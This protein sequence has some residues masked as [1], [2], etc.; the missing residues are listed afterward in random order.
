MRVKNWP[1]SKYR[2][3]PKLRPKLRPK[4]QPKLRPKL[5]SELRP[6]LR[7]QLRPKFRPKLRPKLSSVQRSDPGSDLSCDLSFD[8]CW[9]VSFAMC[10]QNHNYV[11][12][13]THSIAKACVLLWFV[14][15]CT[16]DSL[17]HYSWQWLQ[18][19]IGHMHLCNQLK[20]ND[21]PMRQVPQVLVHLETSWFRWIH[22]TMCG[23]GNN[24][25]LF[26]QLMQ[27]HTAVSRASM[28]LARIRCEMLGY[29]CPGPLAY[30][31]VFL[32]VPLGSLWPILLGVSHRT[33]PWGL[34]WLSLFRHVDL[35]PYIF[36]ARSE[37]RTWVAVGHLGLAQV[38]AVLGDCF[39]SL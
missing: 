34:S 27:W 5:C 23:V 24:A 6:R 14:E 30:G 18:F 37:I 2:I 19:R 12:Q 35:F 25:F 31:L 38:P 7:P 3:W 16:Q 8:L 21:L 39:R 1:L 26:I 11:H 36:P 17:L 9:R 13:G 28:V 20:H 4:L 22:L 33:W 10:S 15:W 32:P 29:W